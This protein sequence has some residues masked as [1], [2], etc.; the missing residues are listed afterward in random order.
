MLWFG[1]NW[2]FFQGE[3]D[4]EEVVF[5][6]GVGFVG[7]GCYGFVCGSGYCVIGCGYVCGG[8]ECVVG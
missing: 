4:D 5:D 3:I 1:Q 6:D 2:G 8:V 7:C